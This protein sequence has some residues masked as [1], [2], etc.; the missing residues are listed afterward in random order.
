MTTSVRSEAKK[1]CIDNG[2][3][4]QMESRNPLKFTRRKSNNLSSTPNNKQGLWK[5][6]KCKLIESLKNSAIS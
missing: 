1:L 5:Y 3:P 6:V 2:H 4:N